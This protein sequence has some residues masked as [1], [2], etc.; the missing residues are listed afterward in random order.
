MTN[1]AQR[2]TVCDTVRSAYKHWTN[3]TLR[4]GDTDRQGHINN[5][6]YCTLLESGRV[7]FLFNDDGSHIAGDNYAFVIAKLTVDY[8]AEMHFP[9][10]AE[11]GSRIL[12]MGRSSFTV[13]QAIF[14]GECCHSS[15]Q[16][17]IVLVDDRTK[18]SAPLT[19]PLVSRL[20]ELM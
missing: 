20:Q 6:A 12:A 5:A 2:S 7:G 19:S 13:G 4:Y 16:S 14:I 18:Q 17:I 8:L 9:G 15:A 1:K 3:V 11:I 10:T